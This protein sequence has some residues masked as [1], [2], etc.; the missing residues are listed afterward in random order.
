MCDRIALA[1]R[2]YEHQHKEHPSHHSH[3]HSQ[4]NKM[5]PLLQELLEVKTV[6]LGPYILKVYISS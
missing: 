3:H 6:L 1:K 4:L 5:K 2:I